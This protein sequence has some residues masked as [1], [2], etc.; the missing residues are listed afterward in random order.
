MQNK[1]KAAGITTLIILS[2]ILF[3][4]LA[5]KYAGYILPLM[6]LTSVFLLMHGVYS[7]IK[8]S[9][10]EKERLNNMIPE[11][12]YKSEIKFHKKE[13]IDKGWTPKTYTDHLIK[14]YESV[15]YALH[16][17]S[18]RITYIKMYRG[19]DWYEEIYPKDDL[20]PSLEFWQDMREYLYTEYYKPDTKEF[21]S[22]EEINEYL[23]NIS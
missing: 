20:K 8:E 15:E 2:V 7:A 9:L 1:L 11:P 13:I 16:A 19:A 21:K 4:I 14:E 23:S 3:F 18:Q 22:M 12:W 6:I 5:F 10:D 17:I